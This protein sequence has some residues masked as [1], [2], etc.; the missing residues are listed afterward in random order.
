LTNTILGRPRA[1]LEEKT[2]LQ[3][4]PHPLESL[5]WARWIIAKLGG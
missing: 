3:K 2:A 5:A 1:E 4:N